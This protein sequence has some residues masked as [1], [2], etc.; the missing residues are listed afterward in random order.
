[1]GC[2][3]VFFETGY[4]DVFFEG[5]EEGCV[6]GEVDDDEVGEGADEDCEETF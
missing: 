4:D 3:A 1:M 5:G 2:L 6:V